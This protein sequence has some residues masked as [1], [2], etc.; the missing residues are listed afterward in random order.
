MTLLLTILR[1]A[2]TTA[3]VAAVLATVLVFAVRPLR[4]R[5]LLGRTRAVRLARGLR[6]L[7]FAQARAFDACSQHDPHVKELEQYASHVLD[8]RIGQLT[9]EVTDAAVQAQSINNLP[10]LAVA[11]HDHHQLVR[12]AVRFSRVVRNANVAT[13]Q[14]VVGRG[15]HV[16]TTCACSRHQP[17]DAARTPGLT[18]LRT[19]E[20]AL[21]ELSYEM[22]LTTLRLHDVADMRALHAARAAA[23]AS[24]VEAAVS[25]PAVYAPA[26]SAPAVYALDDAQV[27]DV[28]ELLPAEHRKQFASALAL[29]AGAL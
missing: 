8:R 15:G 19:L 4:L 21:Q 22:Q 1:V 16:V 12:R 5:L 9:G 3:T 24:P 27:L 11:E 17:L 26:V 13:H 18:S 29:L 28:S 25:A 10:A 2:F 14:L 6:L 23:A 20:P 7:S